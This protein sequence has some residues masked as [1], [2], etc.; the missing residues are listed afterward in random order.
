MMKKLQR[1]NSDVCPFTYRVRLTLAKKK[2]RYENIEIDLQ[3]IPDDYYQISA[4]GKV[5][6][7]KHGEDIILESTILNEYLEDAFP[8]CPLLPASAVQRAKA[9]LWID[10]YNTAFQPN[11]CGLVFELDDKYRNLHR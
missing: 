4:A 11:Y 2:I 8:G 6:L 5:P 1:Y 9:R 3:N 10:Y 7:I